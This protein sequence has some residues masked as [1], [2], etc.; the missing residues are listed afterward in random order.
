MTKTTRRVLL[1]VALLA[2]STALAMVM[3]KQAVAEVLFADEFDDY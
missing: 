2:G 1:V 3:F